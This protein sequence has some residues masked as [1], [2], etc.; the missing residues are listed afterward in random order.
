MD[1]WFFQLTIMMLLV[2]LS[3]FFSG[4]ETALMA[5]N[6]IK[7][8]HKAKEDVRARLV[9]DVLK[10]PDKLIGTILFCNNLVNVALSAIGTGLAIALWG[11]RGIA[12]ATVGITVLLLIFAE[13]TPKTIAAYRSEQIAMT[14]S[15]LLQLFVRLFYPL[16][17][18]LIAISNGMIRLAG[19]YGNGLVRERITKEEI[20]SVIEVGADEGVLD[21]DREEML[22]GIMSLDEVTVGD[23]MVPIRDVIS[24]PVTASYQEVLRTVRESQVSRYPVYENSPHN[25]IG[26]IHVRDFLLCSREGFSLKKILREPHFVPE[27]CSIRQQLLNFQSKRAHL[28]IVVDEYGDIKGIITLEDIIEEIV[29]EIRDEYDSMTSMVQKLP[30]GSYRIKGSLLI[31]DVNRW[32]KLDLPDRGVRTVAGLVF[33]E[34]GRVPMP[35][36]SIVID[37]YKLK[38]DEVKGK[39]IQTVRLWILP[40]ER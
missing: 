7:L 40:G 10:Q 36:D 32:L 20:R 31:R 4:S 1:S 11:D 23:I 26:F 2:L 39:A 6:R 18:I 33:R 28:S 34:L 21:R 35:N 29:G 13:I 16:V 27:L 5:V 9:I 14:V 12:Y 15:P 22:L 17:K 8:R 19:L 38:V 3:A 37:R 30:D 24:L 25:I